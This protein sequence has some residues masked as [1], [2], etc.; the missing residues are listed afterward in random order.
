MMGVDSFYQDVATGIVLLAAVMINSMTGNRK[1]TGKVK[2]SS[3]SAA[4]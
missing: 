1:A 3:T 2:K 4:S